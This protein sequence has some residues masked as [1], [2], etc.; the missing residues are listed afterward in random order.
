MGKMKPIL[1]ELWRGGG[2][3]N[4]TPSA[5]MNFWVRFPREGSPESFRGYRRVDRFES[6]W[7]A[8]GTRPRERLRDNHFNPLAIRSLNSITNC[9]IEGDEL[10]LILSRNQ[11]KVCVGDLIVS[12]DRQPDRVTGLDWAVVPELVIGMRDETV[13]FS[14]RFFTGNCT[15]RGAQTDTQKAALGHMAGCEARNR[16]R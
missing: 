6:H 16:V 1:K 12:R 10:S 11:K 3:S 2:G 9:A 15:E 5:L 4:A 7:D 14:N 13:K 8:I